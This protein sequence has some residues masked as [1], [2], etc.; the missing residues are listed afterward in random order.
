MK[1]LPR[2]ATTLEC[3]PELL[4]MMQHRNGRQPRRDDAGH[5]GRTT[6]TD[7]AD[8]PGQRSDDETEEADDDRDGDGGDDT[9]GDDGKPKGKTD[10]DTKGD[11]E[12]VPLW[13]FERLERSNS[14]LG[15]QN[16]A[17]R[18]EV[19]SLKSNGVKDEDLRKEIDAAA[20]AG[21]ARDAENLSLKQQIA[22]ITTKVDGVEWVN[23]SAAMKLGDFSDV[24]DPATGKVDERAMRTAI[25]RLAKEHPYLV[26]KPGA[27]AG[28]SGGDGGAETDGDG[29]PVATAQ[30]NGQRKGA[31]KSTIDRGALLARNPAL[32]RFQQG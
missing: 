23:V 10:D 32:G 9:K 30:A 3:S 7:P 24:V 14:E 27:A 31:G 2:W 5:P 29:K 28:A 1:L 4:G 6:T 22:F 25:K 19:E 20:A 12:S 16:K 15:R 26:K 13:K 18:E 11:D 21:K 17:L 8:D